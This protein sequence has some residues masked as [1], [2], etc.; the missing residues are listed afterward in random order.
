MLTLSQVEVFPHAQMPRQPFTLIF[1]GPRA[2]VLAE[3]LYV[4]EVE[5]TGPFE[6]YVIPVQ[7]F[8]RDRQDYQA[9]F[10]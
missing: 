8:A 10:N 7:T 3:G 6:L 5:G 9:V 4:F 2:D 1:A